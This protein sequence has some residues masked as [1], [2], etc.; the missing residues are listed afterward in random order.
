[1]LENVNNWRNIAPAMQLKPKPWKA[2]RILRLD[3]ESCVISVPVDSWFLE[4][5]AL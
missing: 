3:V 2:M 1:M 5:Y 4:A